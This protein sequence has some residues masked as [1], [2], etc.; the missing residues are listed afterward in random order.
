MNSRHLFLLLLAFGLTV[1]NYRA[2]AQDLNY[3][4]YTVESG[5]FLPSNEVYGILFDKNNVL[6]ATTDRGIWR[7][8]GFT[9]RQFTVTDG[10]KENSNI[11]IF[12]DSL[13]RIWVA[14]L[15]N[16]LYVIDGDSVKEHP[17][18]ESI[19]NTVYTGGEIQRISQN[20]DGSIYLNYNRP[21]LIR[22]KSGETPRKVESH[23]AGH[24]KASIG[25]HYTAG[26]Y[27][28]DMINFPEKNDLLKTKISTDRGWIYLTCGFFDPKNLFRTDLSPIGK[29]EFLFSF[30]KKVFHIKNGKI[31]AERTFSNAVI[32]IYSDNSGNFWIGLEKEGV[33]RFLN[34]DL[35]SA[36]LGYLPGETISGI[37]QD[38]EGNYWFSTTTNGI[39]QASTLDIAVY[40]GAFTDFNNHVITSMVSDGESLYLGTQSGQ[41][42]KGTE[43]K[44]HE[45]GFQPVKIPVADGSIRKLV[46]TPEKHLIIFNN[47]LSEIDY[48]GRLCGIRKIDR[49]PYAYL[50]KQNGEWLVSFTNSL[51]VIQGSRILRKWEKEL[52]KRTFPGDSLLPT[53]MNRVRCMFLDSS[54]LKWLGSQN[55]GLFSSRDS[56]IFHWAK[57]DRLFGKRIHDIVQAGQNMWISIAD[58]G[59][60]VIRPDSTF[61]TITA[62]KDSL[63]SDIVDVLFAENDSVVWAGTN[64]GLNRITLKGYAGKPQSIAYYTMSQ[65]LPSNRI[66]QIIKHKESI[67]V[68]TSRGAIR[69]SSI[70]A[71]QSEIFPQLVPGPLFVNGRPRELGDGMVLGCN[72]NDL[73]F[74]FKAISYRKPSPLKYRYKLTGMDK[75]YIITN[76]LESRY[77]DLNHGNY[78]FFLNATYTG[79]FDPATEKSFRIQIQRHWYETRLAFLCFGIFLL[80]LIFLI[81][82]LFIKMTRKRE[83]E[84]HRL[85]QAEKRSLLSQMNPHFIFNSLNSIQH[86]IVQHDEFQANNYL[87]NFSGLIRKILENSKKN[88]ITLHEEI[89]S[90]SLYLNMEKLRFENEFEYQIIKDSRIDYNETMIPPMLIQPF[91]E[92]AIWHGLLP[93]KT[94]G[95]IIISF[96]YHDDFF[97]CRIED[98]GIGFE[99]ALAMRGKKESHVSRGIMNVQE[100]IELM[101]KMN[102][103]KIRLVISDLKEIDKTVSGTLIEIYLPIDLKF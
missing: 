61:I 43:L 31:L 88:L 20:Q 5:L 26:E 82:R 65:G 38:H 76:N 22:F 81:F 48:S 64:N 50:R 40:K 75:D 49:F 37:T 32:D 71:T 70:L 86:F 17:L 29:D 102:K 39:Y 94:K 15:N 41:L 92:N 59:I 78:T 69:L 74:K 80:A 63:S 12:N 1:S 83:Q 10:L 91:V 19:H 73:V 85:L 97:Q 84:K 57:I 9:S 98:N 16:Y 77:P 44:N 7:Y 58:Y 21:G 99:K 101:N 36:S 23:R 55:S 68:G 42:F 13:G 96:L 27:H 25:I 89:S 24:D 54:G 53:Y 6:W 90:L 11:R 56:V 4:H 60:A 52:I 79:N 87:T 33:L 93:G 2:H 18:N 47:I 72:E 45:Y 14:S 95:S 103:K 28:W 62:Q 51:Y 34:R 30:S 46:I 35:N 3:T 100:R 8:D 66:S 67:W